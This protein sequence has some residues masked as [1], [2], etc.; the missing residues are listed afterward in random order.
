MYSHINIT[1]RSTIVNWTILII[2]TLLSVIQAYNLNIDKAKIFSHPHKYSHN[3]GSY[4]GFTVALYN[5]PNYKD[6][7]VLVGA[8]RANTT[9]TL[10]IEPGTVYKCMLNSN[11]NEWQLDNTFAEKYDSGTVIRDHSWLGASMSVENIENPRVVV[12]APRWKIKWKD[13]WYMNGICYYAEINANRSFDHSYIERIMS[14][15]NKREQTASDTNNN[16]YYKYGMGLMGFSLSTFTNRNKWGAVLGGP[17]AYSSYGT[18]VLLSHN[19]LGFNHVIPDFDEVSST[20][21]GNMTSGKYFNNDHIQ[22]AASAPRNIDMTGRVRVFYYDDY[23]CI[24]EAID[25]LKGTQKGEYFGAALTSCDIDNDGKDEIIVGAPMWTKNGDEGSVYIFTTKNSKKFKLLLQINGEVKDARF[26]TSVACLGDIDRDG[27]Q[28]IAVGAPYENN[29]GAVYIFNG[30][31]TG[32]SSSWSQRIFGNDFSHTMRGFGF[33]ISEPRDIDGNG[34]FDV[35]IGAYLSGHAVVIRSQ[36]VVSVDIKIY[37]KQMRIRNDTVSFPIRV[38]SSYRGVRSPRSFNTSIKLKVDAL[39]ER[40]YIVNLK[41]EDRSYI[42]PSKLSRGVNTCQNITILFKERNANM[43]DPIEISASLTLDPELETSSVSSDHFYFD[44]PVINKNISK[45]EDNITLEFAVDCGDDN[46]CHSNIELNVTTNLE[47][48]NHFVMGSK[49]AVKL[50]IDIRNYGESAYQTFVHILIP[51]SMGLTNI[52][53]NCEPTRSSGIPEIICN[54]GNP[55]VNQNNLTLELVMKQTRSIENYIE[56]YTFVTTQSQNLNLNQ[57][58]KNLTIY[59]DDDVDIAVSGNAYETS[60]SCFDNEKKQ[61]LEIIKFQHVYQVHKFGVTPIMH[62]HLAISIPTHIIDDKNKQEIEIAKIVRT[63]ISLHEFIDS[64]NSYCIQEKINNTYKTLN[65][66]K[67]NSNSNNYTLYINCTNP[68]IICTTIFCFLESSSNALTIGNVAITMKLQLRN[69]NDN[70]MNGTSTI[71]FESTGVVK[72]TSPFG[73]IQKP[74]E[75][76]DYAQ[77]ATT[78]DSSIAF[79]STFHVPIWI[80]VVS[81]ILGILLLALLTFGLIKLGFFN[82]K[83]KEELETLKSNEDKKHSIILETTS[84]REM[85]DKD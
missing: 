22:F 60:Y 52:P 26:G 61:K 39:H 57:S 49:N 63:D 67:I 8:P 76:L 32:L 7:S 45:T 38:C 13:D 29:Y 48:E 42:M 2:T 11:C 73:I 44:Y 54:M 70:V 69:F 17:G 10:V 1:R 28:D 55:L 23:K 16:G 80:I 9:Q 35:A 51:E 21:L 58:K 64:Q 75:K 62:S 78:F 84:S 36:P 34:Y 68:L 20:Y 18:T 43:I 31:Q 72:I 33:S 14:F 30:N 50:F 83:K 4:F 6:Q 15:T 41:R 71:Y 65:Y 85:L 47:N 19:Q 24:V 66:S 82:R 53:V 46:I 3:R 77:V 56:L 12:C 27:Y 81:V 25:T 74:N 79:A 59:F 40:A 5:S 37:T